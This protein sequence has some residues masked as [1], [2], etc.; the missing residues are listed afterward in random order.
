MSAELR[1]PIHVTA[2]SLLGL[3][4]LWTFAAWLGDDPQ[5]LPAPRA[6][7]EVLARESASGALWF[8]ISQTLWRVA[9]AFTLAMGIG[10]A[11]GIALGLMP[12]L[13]RWADPWVTVFLNLPALVII[14]LCYLWIGLNEVA[15]ITAVAANKT[16]MVTVTIREGVRTLDRGVADL[17]RIYRFSP[18]K[19]L[20]H[21]IWPQLGP[22]VAASTR[23]GLAV[24]WKIVLVVEFLGRSNGVGFQIHLYFQ[25]FDTATVL[26]YALSFTAV[27]LAIEYL[28][29]QRWERHATAW[30]SA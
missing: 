21:V 13:N 20:A 8:H 15:A 4:L 23:N 25:L 14:V 6:V 17:A 2:L 11:L 27:M 30:R 26:A 18:W 1:A 19:R 28:L 16:A 24:I 22:F 12:G 5:V 7:W 10:C 29:V 3:G 9:A